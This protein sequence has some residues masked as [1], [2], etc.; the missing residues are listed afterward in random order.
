MYRFSPDDVDDRKAA[1]QDIA[2][3]TKNAGGEP[4]GLDEYGKAMDLPK[5]FSSLFFI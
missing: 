5:K 4:V 2:T 1:I 3:I